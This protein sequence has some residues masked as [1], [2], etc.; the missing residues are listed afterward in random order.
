MKKQLTILIAL[1]TLG[2]GIITS[3]QKD[4]DPNDNGQ[5]NEQPSDTIPTMTD[6]IH[7]GDTTGMM[8]TIPDSTA[9]YSTYGLGYY[10]I[11]VNGG[12]NEDLRL[13]TKDVGSA[14][15]GHALVI[16]LTCLN[17]RIALFGETI[18]QERYSHT[19]STIWYYVD[20]EYPQFDSICVIHIDQTY[21]CERIDE[22]D[23]VVEVTEKLSLF[24]K[25]TGEMLRKDDYFSSSDVMLRNRSYVIGYEP[26]GWGNDT[27]VLWTNHYNNNCDYFPLKVE[28]YIGFKFIDNDERER[29]GW[30][31][32]ILEPTRVDYWARLL[33]YA[34]QK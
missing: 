6:I 26:T 4:P 24:A 12:E 15:L 30:I 8:V 2:A 16:E 20:P 25:D 18:N 1:M 31:K 9:F 33:E 11:D 14:G 21:N 17:D 34:I 27:L 3:C 13:V 5:N 23:I 19:D 32:V 29:L 7:F 10:S 28:K 22:S